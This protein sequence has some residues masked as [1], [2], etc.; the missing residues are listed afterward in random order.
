MPEKR[1]TLA[2]KGLPTV[3][4]PE[5]DGGVTFA[6]AAAATAD[7]AAD[8]A[9]PDPVPPTAVTATRSDEPTSAE[10]MS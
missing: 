4:L 3:L 6:G 9:V 2:V 8:S 7:V 5:M 10:S 1:P